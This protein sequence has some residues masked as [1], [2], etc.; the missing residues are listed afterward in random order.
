M[1]YYQTN[2]GYMGIGKKQ[3]TTAI[4]TPTCY[5]PILEENTNPMYNEIHLDEC[6]QGLYQGNTKWMKTKKYCDVNF[7]QYLYP[8]TGAELTAAFMGRSTFTASLPTTVNVHTMGF[9]ATQDQ[10][11]TP[12]QKWMTIE[13]SLR[14]SAAPT[15]TIFV[16]RYY[17]V[18]FR[19][20]T[21][22]GEAGQPVKITMDG[23]G[24]DVS[25]HTTARTDTYEANNPFMFFNGNGKYV[26]GM[27]TSSFATKSFDVK[28][29]NVKLNFNNDEEVQTDEFTNR[30]IVQQTLSAEVTVG[31]YFT[32]YW[33]YVRS[34]YGLTTSSTGAISTSYHESEGA[35][36]IDLA[37]GGTGAVAT[38]M[39][40]NL[41]RY[42]LRIT[43]MKLMPHNLN[44][45]N[46]PETMIEELSGIALKKN[47]TTQLWDIECS[48]PYTTTLPT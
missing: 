6:G 15:S 7:S 46:A 31:L 25:I 36:E 24:R 13:K 2:L 29:F 18:K 38:A 28:S 5:L 1:P 20:L 32:D 14:M 43:K 41:R 16:E 33:N 42:K 39:T 8:R 19:S 10:L 4:T 12:R 27:T 44:M 47:T 22:E 35:L 37:Y 3:R 11:T 21:L 26:V 45:N 30:D 17:G 48:L 34:K 23:I 40:S 9:V